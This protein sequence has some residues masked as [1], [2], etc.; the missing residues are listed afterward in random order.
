M[1]K[2]LCSPW[3]ALRVPPAFAP[4]GQLH[5]SP[6]SPVP[7]DQSRGKRRGFSPEAPAHHLQSTRV[8]T[9]FFQNHIFFRFFRVEPAQPEKKK[10][11]EGYRNVT[12][13]LLSHGFGAILVLF[14][15]VPQ[16]SRL[17]PAQPDFLKK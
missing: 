15:H 9:D 1:W 8:H 11:G 6:P 10:E 3:Q 12:K 7:R 4:I 13:N 17:E 2:S 5:Q 16:L 14:F